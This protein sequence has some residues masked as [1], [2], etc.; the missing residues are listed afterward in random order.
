M[1]ATSLETP[2]AYEEGAPFRSLAALEALATLVSVW[3]FAPSAPR[4]GDATA[5]HRGKT[6]NRGNPFALTRLQTSRYM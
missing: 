6:D 1:E 3:V 2:W 4:F 5:T